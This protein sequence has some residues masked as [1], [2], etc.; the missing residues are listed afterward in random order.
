MALLQPGV[1]DPFQSQFCGGSIIGARWIV[2]A[3]HC[4]EGQSP[5]AIQ[6]VAGIT[7]LPDITPADRRAVDRIDVHPGWDSDTFRND[8]AL[9]RLAAPIPLDGVN[10]RAIALPTD[11]DPAIWPTAGTAAYITGWGSLANG[12]PFPTILQQ[13]LIQVLTSPSSDICGTY[14]ADYDR[15]IM[16]CAG[17]PGGGIDTCQGDSGGPL[18]V[19]VS[20][21][22]RLAGITS[23]GNVCASAIDPGVYTRVTTYLPWISS[24]TGITGPTTDPGV[25]P[26][27]DT[28]HP[29][30]PARI[31]DTRRGIGG[32]ATPVGA[33]QTRRLTVTGVGGV[34]A[35]ATAVALNVTVTNPTQLSHL[36]VWPTGTDRPN[37]SNLNYTPGRT[38]PNTVI[39]GVGTNGQIDIFNAVGTV[40]VIV[41]VMGWF[42]T[43]GITPVRPA[44]I[45]DTRRG[46][47]GPATPVGAAQTRRLT[48]TGVGG[49]PA[50][51]TAVALNVTVTNPTQLSHLTV[52]PTGTDRP[53]SSNLNYTPGRTI[54]NTVIVGVGTNG[55]IDIFNAVG[56]V[57]VI[58]DVMGWFD[59]DGITPV[60][61]ARIMDTR[62]N[63]CG[64]RLIAGETRTLLVAGA[65]P[66]P[67]TGVG[68][69][70]L[71]VTAASPSNLSHLTVWPTG[72]SRPNS[73]N[74]NFQAGET[75]P[76]MVVVGVGA[77][78]QINL[79]NAVGSVDVIV[80]VMGWFGGTAPPGPRVPCP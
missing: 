59:T 26:E 31:M 62:R 71:N 49:V 21:S 2:T 25:L 74:L 23:F 68:A 46:I 36:T 63:T 35:D 57:D 75:I 80:D 14:G 61:P 51:A 19:Q 10:T 1:A 32:P 79:S 77:G 29:V 38:I 56:T 39:V 17:V 52:W 70:A 3:A 13:A 7:E 9:L 53:N 55:Q 27:G 69:V 76:N 45:M 15:V 58:V 24:L 4:V 8:I 37:S 78:G 28:F 6:V 41:D 20:G 72:T 34:P 22:W 73:S 65:G 66:V 18:A 64:T 60:R 44:R 16:L 54:P 43:D 48:V 50:D 30:R 67:S 5:S 40:D 42:D 11:I 33:A 12:G 47:G